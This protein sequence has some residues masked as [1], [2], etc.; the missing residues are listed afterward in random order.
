M[1]HLFLVLAA[2]GALVACETVPP[3][4]A[5]TTG[6]SSLTAS[7][8]GAAAAAPAF[9]PPPDQQL[10][11]LERQLSNAAQAGGLGGALA[12]VIDPTDGMAIRA[13]VTYSAADVERGLAPPAGA[14]PIYWQP[15]RVHVSSSGDMGMTSG[16]Y[17]Q[18]MTG[19][20]AVQG[21][22]VV[23]WRRDSAGVW[24]VLTE[25]RIAD[26]ARAAATRRR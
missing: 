8:A 19:S 13:G 14:G 12:S 4:F 23:V 26:P 18:V 17:V 3:G 24:K 1:R 21:R 22:Y 5:Q 9:A 16:R 6:P 15:D 10:L 20:E 11:E 25:T 2:A 7:G